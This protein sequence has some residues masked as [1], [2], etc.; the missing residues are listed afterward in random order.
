MKKSFV[1][2]NFTILAKQEIKKRIHFA[3]FIFCI[4]LSLETE[5]GKTGKRQA[6]LINDCSSSGGAPV[7]RQKGL[8]HETNVQQPFRAVL[9]A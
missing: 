6:L 2:L 1:Q 4:A 8:L 7:A 9:S 5:R 3:K